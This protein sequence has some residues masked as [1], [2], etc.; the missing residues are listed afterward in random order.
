MT[1]PTFDKWPPLGPAYQ[2]YQNGRG[3][4]L[5]R[6]LVIAEYTDKHGQPPAEVY[7]CKP[8]LWLAGP[9][10]EPQAPE[11]VEA[12]PALEAEPVPALD[13]EQIEAAPVFE[14]QAQLL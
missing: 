13:L 1:A 9:V 2:A 3:Q 8:F 5:T 4:T 14:G 7:F 12:V 11:A 6:E 10:P